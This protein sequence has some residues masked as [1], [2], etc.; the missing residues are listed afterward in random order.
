MNRLLIVAIF[1]VTSLIVLST[2][3][4][5]ALQ[6][7]INVEVPKTQSLIDAH[8]CETAT[9][10]WCSL[11]RT[12]IGNSDP[13]TADEG[14][15]TIDEISQLTKQIESLIS[16]KLNSAKETNFGWKIGGTGEKNEISVNGREYNISEIAKDTFDKLAE[17]LDKLGFVLDPNNVETNKEGSITGYRLENLV[18]LLSTNNSRV[19]CGTLNDESIPTDNDSAEISGLVS[20]EYSWPVPQIVI[21]FSDKTDTRAR[22][23]ATYK[24]QT[25]FFLAAKNDGEWSLVHVGESEYTCSEVEE[26]NFPQYMVDDCIIP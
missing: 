18:C 20:Q 11:K 24:D 10:A 7:Q 19:T 17:A 5:Y 8:G 2:G 6:N 23:V 13:C 25:V 15:Q 16:V 9:Q 1:V 14:T 4:I 12:C 3:A 26:F 22:G 21:K